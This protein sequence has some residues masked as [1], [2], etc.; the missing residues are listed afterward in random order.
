[1]EYQRKNM[2]D[3]NQLRNAGII[4]PTGNISLGS[5]GHRYENIYL[6]GNI[7]LG[8]TIATE[9]S[10]V[11]PK[12]SG[13]T[14]VGD[15]TAADPTGGQTITITGTGFA[16]GAAV[17]VAGS[18]ISVVS[19]LSSTQITFN[20]PA[21][22]AGNYT[23]IM[24]NQDGGT[25]TFIPG[26]QYSG[27]PTWSTSAGS[28]A[29]IYETTAFSS[30]LTAT[31]DSPVSYSIAAGTLPS[32]IS[33]TSSSGVLSGNAPAQ[34]AG[35]TTYSF[36][37][38]AIDGENQD[39]NRNF[40]ITVNADTVTWS[41]PADGTTFTLG[42]TLPMS[43]VALT[44]TSAAGK[45]ISYSAN[46]LPTGLSI[47]GANI[48]GTPTVIAN[49]SSVIT[50]TASATNKLAA[51]TLNWIV[52]IL[53][54]LYFKY[55]TLQLSAE[56]SNNA[57]NNT[58]LDSST[59][60]F[61]V[62]RT[63]TPT[64]GSFSPFSQTGWGAYLDGASYLSIPYNAAFG[65]GASD[66]T[67]E[68]W[69]N[70][71]AD[72]A[73]DTG[74]S[75]TRDIFLMGS[76]RT[77]GATNSPAWRLTLNG[78]ST[79]TATALK[80][81]TMNP[82]D[83]PNDLL[84]TL[85]APLNKNQWYHI[86]VTRV[87]NTATLFLDGVVQVQ[88]TNWTVQTITTSYPF[89]IGSLLPLSGGTFRAYFPGYISNVRVI[90]GTG[91]YSAEFTPP[92]EPLTAITNTV[93]LMLGN[94]NISDASTNNFAIT[95]TGTVTTQ[96]FGPFAPAN[97]YSTSTVGSS[98][99]FNGTADYL[100]LP[101]STQWPMTGDFTVECWV[102][103]TARGT[104][105][106]LIDQ[107]SAVTA[108]IGSWKLM[109]TTAGIPTIYPNGST[110][111]IAHQTAIN[112]NTWNHIAATRSGTTVRIFLNGAVGTSTGTTS[113]TVGQNA[114]LWIG[115][116]HS[117]GPTNYFSGYMSTPRIVKG[118][119]LYTASFTSPTTPLTAVSNTQLLLSGTNAGIIDATAKNV[120]ATIGDAKISTTQS[121]FGSGSMYFDGTGDRLTVPAAFTN[122]IGYVFTVE[123]WV[124]RTVTGVTQTIVGN[125]I[126]S[127][128]TSWLIEIQAN[129]TVWGGGWING[130]TSTDTVPAD[131]WT[132]IALVGTELGNI[133]IYING[134]QSGT[135]TAQLNF[136]STTAIS[137]GGMSNGSELFT[138]YIDDLRITRGVAR[139]TGNFNVPVVEFSLK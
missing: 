34:L 70:I 82:T 19:V 88:N 52:A 115:T 110:G 3:Y 83:T 72:A 23:L 49:S 94:N 40:S 95:P 80:W 104:N 90:K 79:Q 54:D 33:L 10:L 32:G 131:T 100:S 1:M 15:D 12:I 13:L 114:T 96:A 7:T 127:T 26:M 109:V 62:T 130:V 93:I 122:A 2:S 39:T 108:G 24:V 48:I 45:S 121:K 16:T 132:H 102:Y 111:P 120:V 4:A 22:A 76:E 98:M 101:A 71:T 51:I 123:L 129:G 21:K 44:S 6:L 85:A 17:Y 25:A 65:F 61:T 89:R 46:S 64:Q 67:V 126:G 57:T 87:G 133:A 119:A 117:A 105:P 84:K 36:S 73:L 29:S 63:G 9:S 59:N 58:F 18:L 116:Q 118:T 31:S 66:F 60:N 20:S 28:L 75:G 128:N 74:G 42:V 97:E 30:T 139:Y 137:V 53:A 5:D 92:T 27:T 69:F 55:T 138:G 56:G 81:S 103:M 78:S 124:Y 38:A 135:S 50:A 107:Y 47:S 77:S 43:N 136:T 11:S 86:A 35:S 41:S 112:L 14:Y 8:N 113:A 37:S 106:T 99:Y 125:N 134:T 91:V 68:C